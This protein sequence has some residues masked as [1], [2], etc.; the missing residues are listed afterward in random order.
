MFL[1][2]E[3]LLANSDGDVILLRLTMIIPSS[4]MYMGLKPSA[5]VWGGEVF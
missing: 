4:P 1:D 5:V 3:S 2:I